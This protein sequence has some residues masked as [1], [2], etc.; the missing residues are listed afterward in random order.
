MTISYDRLWKLLIDK[1][2]KKTDLKPLTGI[3]TQVLADMGKGNKI[4]MGALIKICHTFKVQPNDI[5]ELIWD[6]EADGC[7]VDK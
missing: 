2:L 6:E 1:K 4:S 3:T 7:P 5:M